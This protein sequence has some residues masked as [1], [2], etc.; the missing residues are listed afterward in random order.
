METV[1][2]TTV[3]VFVI[4]GVLQFV[5]LITFFV[6]ARALAN[7]SESMRKVNTILNAWQKETGIGWTYTCIKCKEKW[8][9]KLPACPHCGD[10]KDYTPELNRVK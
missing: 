9:G 10:P 5:T 1:A 6:M 8:E 7:I 3:T 4:F 2:E